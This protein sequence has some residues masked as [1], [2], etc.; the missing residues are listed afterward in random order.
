MQIVAISFLYPSSSK[1][2]FTKTTKCIV[3]RD[4]CLKKVTTV[5]FLKENRIQRRNLMYPGCMFGPQGGVYRDFFTF[6][7]F[8]ECLL[9]F[10]STQF[11]L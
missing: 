3:Q 7:A 1:F 4:S 11:S 6:K 9:H 8:K 5:I 2:I 10:H